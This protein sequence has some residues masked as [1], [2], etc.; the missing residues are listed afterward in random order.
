[1]CKSRRIRRGRVDRIEK[2]DKDGKE[3]KGQAKR[4]TKGEGWGHTPMVHRKQKAGTYNIH[5]CPCLLTETETHI[6]INAYHTLSHK[7]KRASSSMKTSEV[8]GVSAH[9]QWY[10]DTEGSPFWDPTFL[11]NYQKKK[12]K[13][14]KNRNTGTHLGSY[15]FSPSLLHS[16]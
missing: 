11:I 12:K 4:G 2:G 6:H 9:P 15:S 7:S 14:K 3:T 10:A 5:T 1:M 13:K 16:I 8:C